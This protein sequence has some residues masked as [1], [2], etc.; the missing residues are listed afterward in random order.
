MNYYYN[1]AIGGLKFVTKIGA[2]FL[3]C[4]MGINLVL[5]MDGINKNIKAVGATPNVTN[6]PTFEQKFVNLE[7]SK[8]AFSIPTFNVA[9][10]SSPISVSA[11]E[12]PTSLFS[13]S[14]ESVAT[15]EEGSK[16]IVKTSAT[17]FSLSIPAIGLEN[18]SLHYGTNRDIP[19]IDKLLLN[20]P[21]VE[22]RDA[23]DLCAESGNTYVYGHSE[24][25]SLNIQGK[26]VRIFQNLH[27]LETGS[28]IKL[29]TVGGIECKYKVD[30]WDRIE[31]DADGNVL[32][33]EYI[34]AMQYPEGQ[35]EGKKGT[36]TIQTCKLGSST[37]RLLLRAS[38]I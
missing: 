4:I 23:Q 21:V 1:R 22:N 32:Y 28:E 5:M 12:S 19:S 34:R 8:L 27:K 6:G 20:S 16:P 30:F 14:R 15:P 26:G 38:R 10:E 35:G 9:V 29:V 36:L 25:P 7:T 37:T 3:F 11:S 13:L 24:P 17:P 2:I 18:I 33:S 31:T